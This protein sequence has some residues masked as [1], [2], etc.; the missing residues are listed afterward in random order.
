MNLVIHAPLDG[1]ATA[2]G[3]GDGADHHAVAAGSLD[4]VPR[5]ALDGTRVPRSLTIVRFD[6]RGRAWR[7]VMVR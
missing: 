4:G 1:A 6:R 7:A 2:R 5:R 3:Q